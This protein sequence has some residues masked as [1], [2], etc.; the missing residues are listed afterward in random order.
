M[1]SLMMSCD[2]MMCDFTSWN[3]R[4]FDKNVGQLVYLICRSLIIILI[5][6]TEKGRCN[7]FL[8]SD[9]NFGID[10]VTVW[11]IYLNVL[12]QQIEVERVNQEKCLV[13]FAGC[14]TL[15]CNQQ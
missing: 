8:N 2:F 7:L 14:I 3:L 10:G 12:R 6:E 5:Y 1:M 13:E 15:V 9:C 4:N 11:G